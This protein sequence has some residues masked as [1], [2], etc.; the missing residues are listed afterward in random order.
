MRIFFLSTSMGMGGAD[1]QILILARAMRARGHQ[2]RIVSLA[3]LGPMGLEARSEGIPTESLELRRNLGIISRPF[4]LIRMIRA[5]RPDVLHSHMVHANLLARAV[6]PLARVPTLVSTIHSINDGGRVRIA[7]YRLTRWLVDRHTIISQLAAERYIGIGAVPA[8]RL[9]VIPNA[10][11]TSRFRRLFQARA[12]VRR[13]LGL[14]DEFAWLA[15][16][17]FEDP[18]DY[19]TMIAAFSRLAANQP[20]SRLLLAGKGSLQEEVAALVRAAGLE[21]RVRFL[22]VRR[23]IPELMS[24]ADAYVLS[25]A[26]EGMPVVL[27]EA[28]AVELPVVATRVG[29][30]PEVVEDGTTGLLVPPGDPVLLG[31]AMMRIEALSPEARATMGARGRALVEHRYGTATVMKMWDRLY[32]ECATVSSDSEGAGGQR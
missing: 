3:P 26:W 7:A 12:A 6:R 4:R 19:P 22:G 29:G 18:K 2:V 14:G 20:A 21:Q 30:I 17:R 15:V 11:D 16:G 24:A 25:S 28:A 27:L 10:V 1:Q 32:S 31:D 8:D 13:E 9:Q 23:D 5:W